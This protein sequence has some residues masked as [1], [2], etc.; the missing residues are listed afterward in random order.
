MGNKGVR[1]YENVSAR[2]E[3]RHQQRSQVR[4]KT[5]EFDL[6]AI[7]KNGK[8]GER[9]AC[10]AIEGWRNPPYPAFPG[11]KFPFL[12]LRVFDQ[13][14]GRVSDDAMDGI[15]RAAPQPLKRVDVDNLVDNGRSD[16]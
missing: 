12:L 3:C 8:P 6:L 16:F 7:V 2:N 13:A 15:L 4:K 10:T 5:F 1:G 14:V 9:A 11:S